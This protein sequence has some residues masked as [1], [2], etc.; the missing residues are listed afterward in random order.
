MSLLR[1]GMSSVRVVVGMP[2]NGCVYARGLPRRC[3]TLYS[4]LPMSLSSTRS[5]P[6][7]KHLRQLSTIRLNSLFGPRDVLRWDGEAIF[8]VGVTG[9]RLNVAA[10]GR[11]HAALFSGLPEQ[12]ISAIDLEPL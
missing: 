1:L 9:H 11:R 12:R 10:S 3:S 6:S 2:H 5:V 4:L 8:L 7:L